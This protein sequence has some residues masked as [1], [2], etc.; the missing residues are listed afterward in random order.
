MPGNCVLVQLGFYKPFKIVV[1]VCV[2]LA[3]PPFQI[4]TMY[5]C[6]YVWYYTS[7]LFETELHAQVQVGWVQESGLSKSSCNVQFGLGP[8]KEKGPPC[9]VLEILKRENHERESSPEASEVCTSH[10]K[11]WKMNRVGL[12]PRNL[13]RNVKSLE[14]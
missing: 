5:G 1:I 13:A 9:M 2:S 10:R 12:I 11:V 14:T 8:K 3:L 4:K 6:D 7:I